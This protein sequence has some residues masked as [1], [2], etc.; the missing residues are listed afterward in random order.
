MTVEYG[1]GKTTVMGKKSVRGESYLFFTRENEVSGAVFKMCVFRE[2]WNGIRRLMHRI[3]LAI[4]SD[5]HVSI[6]LSTGIYNSM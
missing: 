6:I 5:R 1:L 3:N 4:D 2:Q